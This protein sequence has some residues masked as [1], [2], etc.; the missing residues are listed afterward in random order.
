MNLS[1]RERGPDLR[2]TVQRKVRAERAE[3]GSESSI[4]S[5]R[6]AGGGILVSICSEFELS[7]VSLQSVREESR[8]TELQNR[9]VRSKLASFSGDRFVL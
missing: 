7:D 2:M 9:E 1:C 5:A 3:G 4:F 8:R 6:R